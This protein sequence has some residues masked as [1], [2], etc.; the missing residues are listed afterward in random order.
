VREGGAPHAVRALLQHGGVAG[1]AGATKDVRADVSPHHACTWHAC[2]THTP[3]TRPARA[4]HAR[5]MRQA[6]WGDH[7]HPIY[8]STSVP[9][10][11]DRIY[12]SA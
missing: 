12:T 8:H 6:A 2:A 3:R 4:R 1:V 9:N 5:G 7:H 11:P 10:R